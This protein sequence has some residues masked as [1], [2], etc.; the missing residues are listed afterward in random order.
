MGMRTTP[1]AQTEAQIRAAMEAVII[2]QNMTCAY[3]SIVTVAGEV[4][5]N[6]HYHNSVGAGDLLL[7]DVG[8]ETSDG[9]ASDITRTWPVSGKF[10]ATQARPV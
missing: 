3:G 7:A 2:G 8:A 1:Q 9:W 4:L 10:S 6:H 5:H